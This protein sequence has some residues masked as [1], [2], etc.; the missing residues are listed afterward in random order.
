MNAL[1][2]LTRDHSA[3]KSLFSEFDRTSKTSEVKRSELF[4]QIRREL[5]LHSKAEE[6]IFY[7]A[8]KAL[9]EEG[10]RLVSEAV[11]DHRDID[12][13]LTQISRL[14]PS[15]RNFDE[16]F[17]MLFEHVDHHVEKEEGEIFRFAKKHCSAQQLEDLGWQIEVRKGILDQQMAA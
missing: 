8:L 12:R 14:E 2:L 1:E 13:L 4:V 10:G 17:E 15:D 9:N 16:K 7:P 11:K 3:V 5:Q 6:E